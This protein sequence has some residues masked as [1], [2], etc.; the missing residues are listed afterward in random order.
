MSLPLILD[1]PVQLSSKMLL[2][3]KSQLSLKISQKG[4][5]VIFEVSKQA[6]N[7]INPHDCYLGQQVLKL[8]KGLHFEVPAINGLLNL[9]NH[10]CIHILKNALNSF[11]KNIRKV[12]ILE[13]VLQ[14]RSLLI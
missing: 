10:E 11:T 8:I 2:D 1:F 14:T 7:L 4:S 13:H 3:I 12:I 6:E 5:M 9:V